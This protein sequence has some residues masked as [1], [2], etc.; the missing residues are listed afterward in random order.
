MMGKGENHC[1]KVERQVR[2]QQIGFLE[3]KI[4][5]HFKKMID[6]SENSGKMSRH[7][8]TNKQQI[9]QNTHEK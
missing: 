8:Y 9:E 5:S 1:R 2:S 6:V 4:R 7:R 3:K